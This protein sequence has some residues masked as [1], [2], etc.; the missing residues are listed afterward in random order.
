MIKPKDSLSKVILG[1]LPFKFYQS[2]L[3]YAALWFMGF[4][5]KSSPDDMKTLPTM[6]LHTSTYVMA[7]SATVFL[8]DVWDLLLTSLIIFLST[9]LEILHFWNRIC[10]LVIAKI[11]TYSCC[12]HKCKMFGYSL[13]LYIMSVYHLLLE[14]TIPLS[15]AWRIRVV[16]NNT[17][18]INAIFSTS[19]SFSNA[20]LMLKHLSK[21]TILDHCFSLLYKTNLKA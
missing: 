21:D 18:C 3:W 14:L 2:K 7:R 17:V 4:F 6:L 5:W 20:D 16:L 15:L 10:F 9:I 19:S 12:I 13:P 1:N 11:S 8:T